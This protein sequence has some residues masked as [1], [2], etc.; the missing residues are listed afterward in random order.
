[1]YKLIILIPPPFDNGAFYEQWPQFLH[2]AEQMP[3]LVRE[4]SVHPHAHVFGPYRLEILHELYFESLTD[5]EAA[6]LS[7]E[8]QAAGDLLQRITNRRVTLLIAEHKEDSLE[9]IRS[10]RSPPPAA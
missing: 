6:L 3:G 4:S 1:M 7:P 10:F 8:G 5:L 9:R 2:A